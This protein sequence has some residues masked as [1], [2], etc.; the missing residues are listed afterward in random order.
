MLVNF[1]EN[2]K[3]GKIESYLKKGNKVFIASKIIFNT[4]F[5]VIKSS[6]TLIYKFFNFATIGKTPKT[7]T[8]MNTNT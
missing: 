2:L 6:S 7:V 1:Q 5:V 4:V 3:I 8:L